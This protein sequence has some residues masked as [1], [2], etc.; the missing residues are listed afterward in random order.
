MIRSD[1]PIARHNLG[2]RSIFPAPSH[3]PSACT[4][5]A[6]F[7]LLPGR[8]LVEHHPL[9]SSE[10]LTSGTL[11]AKGDSVSTC[12]PPGTRDGN[13]NSIHGKRKQMGLSVG[14]PVSSPPAPPVALGLGNF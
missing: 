11:E 9:S 10:T 13:S 2:P 4:T 12:N 5:S 14:H 3:P 8:L 7:R 6:C 1:L